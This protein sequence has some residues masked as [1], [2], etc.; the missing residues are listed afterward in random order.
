MVQSVVANRF[1]GSGI[2]GEFARSEN[3]RS[4]GAILVETSD[5]SN[6][7]GRVV[8]SSAT[9]GYEVRVGFTG[10]FA[11]IIACPKTAV[12]ATLEA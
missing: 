1:L 5:T 4:R 10:N 2:V 9:N 11:G 7:P 12:R 8:L 6:M 3:Q